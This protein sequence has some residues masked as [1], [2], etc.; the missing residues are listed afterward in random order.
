V[1]AYAVVETMMVT[2]PIGLVMRVADL[3]ADIAKMKPGYEIYET[4]KQLNIDITI[5]LENQLKG[6]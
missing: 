5:E 4:A 3:L 6:R 2:L 1:E